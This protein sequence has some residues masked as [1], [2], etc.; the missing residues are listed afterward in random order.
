MESKES[1][2]SVRHKGRHE[3][4]DLVALANSF[5]SVAGLVPYTGIIHLSMLGCILVGGGKL[6]TS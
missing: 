1:I 6:V 4:C 5:E 3:Y 2:I